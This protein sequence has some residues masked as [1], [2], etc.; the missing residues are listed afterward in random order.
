MCDVVCECVLR[1]VCARE[2]MREKKESVIKRIVI[3]REIG[4]GERNRTKYV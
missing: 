1:E 3:E 2:T 4:S